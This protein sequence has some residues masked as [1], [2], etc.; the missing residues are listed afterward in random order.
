MDKDDV[1]GTKTDPHPT[2]GSVRFEQY[3]NVVDILAVVTD[4]P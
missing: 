4:V 1:E 2:N 3:G